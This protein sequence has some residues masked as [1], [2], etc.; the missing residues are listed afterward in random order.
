MKRIPLTQG[1]FAMVDDADFEWLTQWKWHY[2]DGYAAR[3]ERVNGR[4]VTIFMHDQIMGRA[5][6]MEVDHESGLKLHNSRRNLRSATHLQN[7]G[8]QGIRLSN[9]SGYKGVHYNAK[10]RK[11]V[12]Q[13]CFNQERVYLGLWHSRE[14]AALVYNAF[15]LAYFGDFARLNAV[16]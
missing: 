12:A 3:G 8:N 2:H 13:L 10:N 4:M 9:T 5:Q 15:A 14:M 11:W 7:M 6:G 1:K 16:P